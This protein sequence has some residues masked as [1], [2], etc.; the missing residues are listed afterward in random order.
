[1][2]RVNE[3]E[4]WRFLAQEL[5][6]ST[7]EICSISKS[8]IDPVEK[9]FLCYKSR[10]GIPQRFFQSLYVTSRSINLICSSNMQDTN[11][12]ISK[13]KD[14]EVKRKIRD[15]LRNIED[16]ELPKKPVKD[17]STVISKCLFW[18]QNLFQQLFF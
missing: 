18:I 12:S 2:L 4:N 15:A 11:L 3:E 5:H 13:M 10:G 14:E 17:D 6:F 9:L 7:D 1:M 8:L 16:G